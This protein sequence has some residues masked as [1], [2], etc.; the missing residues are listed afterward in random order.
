MWLCAGSAIGVITLGGG[1]EKS[2]AERLQLGERRDA[3]GVRVEAGANA[4]EAR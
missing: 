3:V 2:K 1:T 4:G